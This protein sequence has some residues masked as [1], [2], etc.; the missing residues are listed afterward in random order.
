MRFVRRQLIDG[1]EGYFGGHGGKEPIGAP[2]RYGGSS[3]PRRIKAVPRPSPPFRPGSS[4]EPRPVHGHTQYLRTLDFS[5]EISISRHPPEL[6][7]QFMRSS[8]CLCGA[9]AIQPDHEP[10]VS[11]PACD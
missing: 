4:T 2:G 3:P 10:S 8:P 11:T 1:G 5:A 6:T 7:L 9:G